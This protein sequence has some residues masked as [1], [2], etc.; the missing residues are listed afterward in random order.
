MRKRNCLI[1]FR[2]ADTRLFHVRCSGKPPPQKGS[3]GDL[4]IATIRVMRG[5]CFRDFLY[6]NGNLDDV[7]EMAFPACR[8]ESSEMT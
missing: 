1:V 5:G 6:L 4:S 2:L 3:G 7:G 8:I